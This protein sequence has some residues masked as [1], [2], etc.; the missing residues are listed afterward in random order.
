MICHSRVLRNP[1]ASLLTFLLIA[2][3]APPLAAQSLKVMS[4]GAFKPVVLELAST[5]ESA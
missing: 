4:A 3:V 2:S 1:L 5:F